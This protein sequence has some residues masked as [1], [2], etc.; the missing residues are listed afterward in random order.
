VYQTHGHFASTAALQVFSLVVTGVRHACG[1]A[2]G[3]ALT[4]PWWACGLV[5]PGPDTMPP[6]GCD[7]PPPF[8]VSDVWPKFFVAYSCGRSDCHDA[9]SGH[10]YFRLQSLDGVVA[11][12][13]NDPVSSWPAAWSANLRAVQ[14]N[15]SCANPTASAVLAVPE[16]RG[17]PHPPGVVVTDPQGADDLFRM[18]LQ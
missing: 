18:W 11:P 6:S 16:G 12:Q 10:G 8:F 9:S 4:L 1:L 17:S 3:L 13:P 15:L 14:H 5:D 7:A 2:L